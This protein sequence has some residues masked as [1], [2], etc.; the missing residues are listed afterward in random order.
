MLGSKL[1]KLEKNTTQ[2]NL[3]TRLSKKPFLSGSAKSQ[4]YTEE[5]HYWSDEINMST[6]H[7]L[8]LLSWQYWYLLCTG[9]RYRFYS[10]T[11]CT[12]K[13]TVCVYVPYLAQGA[14]WQARLFQELSS[15]SCSDF[16]SVSWVNLRD[17][18]K[19]AY[20]VMPHVTVQFIY[21]LKRN[22]PQG[23]LPVCNSSRKRSFHSITVQRVCIWVELKYI[24][25]L[26]KLA[27]VAS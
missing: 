11:R 5:Y 18:N 13:I 9:W 19:N 8:S 21:I 27:T 4:I 26:S 20:V 17:W 10:K 15:I 23:I 1:K 14:I 25:A 22:T 16:S 2:Q 6:T 12:W 3:F 7:W 24:D